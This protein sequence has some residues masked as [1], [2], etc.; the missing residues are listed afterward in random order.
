ME[1][2]LISG[3][4]RGDRGKLLPLLFYQEGQEGQYCPIKLTTRKRVL[5][6]LETF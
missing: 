4:G 2:V 1:Q 6:L 3:S 5:E